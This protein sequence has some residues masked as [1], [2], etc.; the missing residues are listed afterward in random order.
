MPTETVAESAPDDDL[1]VPAVVNP[2]YVGSQAC[3][4][5]HAARFDTFK[6]SRHHWASTAPQDRP[7][8]AAFDAGGSFA[9]SE[10]SVRYAMG[11][12][13]GCYFQKTIQATP[14]GQR[15]TTTPIGMVYGHGGQFDEVYF[16]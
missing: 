16:A 6:E 14:Q 4:A 5:C 8:P 9:S 11:H 15:E 1:T 2:G 13:G 3:A 10:P 7:M 12:E